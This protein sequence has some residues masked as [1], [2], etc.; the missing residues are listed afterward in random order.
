MRLWM[1][2]FTHGVEIGAHLAYI[3]HYARTKDDNV[4][5]IA[6]DELEHQ[7]L[8]KEILGNYNSKTNKFIDFVFY[9][10]GN[11]VRYLCYISPKFMLDRVAMLLELFA[12]FSYNKL[13][14]E[15]PDFELTLNKM[16][17]IEQKHVEYFK[18]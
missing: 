16:G 15:F 14:Q 10:I 3:G 18:K 5:K 11:M 6:E 1:L 2:Q 8:L 13:A 12:V 17:E 7:R 4:R 9:M